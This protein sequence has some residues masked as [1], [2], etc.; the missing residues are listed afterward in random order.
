[1]ENNRGVNQARKLLKKSEVIGQ[2]KVDL[3][4]RLCSVVFSCD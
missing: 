4:I 1:M 2:T 3:T